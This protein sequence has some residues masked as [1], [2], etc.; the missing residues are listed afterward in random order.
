[1]RFLFALALSLLFSFAGSPA[2]AQ[3]VDYGW[4]GADAAAKA[5]LQLADAL[6]EL[7]VEGE[8]TPWQGRAI[9]LWTFTR[10]LNGGE[11]LPNKAQAIG[12]CVSFGNGHACEYSQ[13]VSI[14]LSG[15]DSLHRVFKPYI[16]GT[17]RV[18][19]GHVRSR[20]DGST[21]AWQAAALQQYGVIAEDFAGV[22]AYSKSAA[23]AWSGP[24]GPPQSMVAEGKRHLVQARL[25][26]S[27]DQACE[28]LANGWAVAVCSNAGF[29]PTLDGKRLVGTWNRSWAHCM[30]FV[31]YDDQWGGVY[32]L[33]SWGPTEHAPLSYYTGTG[34][35]PGGFWIK[36]SDADRML[37]QGD[38]Y[39]ISFTG[40]KRRDLFG[41]AARN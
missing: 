5:R 32:C 15:D 29:T 31:G 18:F 10:A 21:G 23:L 39:A 40:F 38:S 27:Y 41:D 26:K 17:G 7:K 4:L 35:P 37:M 1:M 30:C 25:V 2:T 6:P 12:D 3:L 11:H 22:P 13:A 33:N 20:G 24:P 28:A 34:E 36:R 19:V 14:F 16:Y 8:A 9:S